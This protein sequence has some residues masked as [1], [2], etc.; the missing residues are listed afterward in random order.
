MFGLG[1]IGTRGGR[2]GMENRLCCL[3][4][5]GGVISSFVS[6]VTVSFDACVRGGRMGSRSV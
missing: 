4:C 5:I 6:V 3:F 2:I 1:G